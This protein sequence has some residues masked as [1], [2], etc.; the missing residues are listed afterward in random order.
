MNN[1][2]KKYLPYLLPL[3]FLLV[4]A[5]QADIPLA[6]TPTAVWP[7]DSKQVQLTRDIVTIMQEKHFRKQKLDDQFS[8]ALLDNYLAMLDPNHQIFLQSD[9][10]EFAR[11]RNLLD[12]E[13]QIGQLTS[14]RAIYQ[15]FYDRYSSRLAWVATRIDPLLKA[16]E[17]NGDDMIEV[18]RKKSP[19]PADAAAADKL[20]EQYVKNS[21][22]SLQ[23][24]D[25]PTENISA[26]LTRRFHAQLERLQKQTA[27]DNFEIF[28]NAYTEM[29][30]PHT[31]YMSPKSSDNFDISMSLSLEGIGAVLEK[32]DE[33]TKVT[34]LVPAGPAAK[35]GE[36]KP[37]DHIVAIAQGQNGEQWE[38]VIG[39]RLDEVVELI[40][41]KADT[42]VRLQIKRGEDQIKTIAIRREK[43]KLEDQAASKKIIELP[44]DKNGKAYK[45]GVI[46]VPNF[47][48]DF[49]ALRRR[50]PD[51]K[52]TT[53]D[54][55]RILD[56]L[57][58]AK[59]DGV[60]IDL[61]DNG[62][63][64]LLEATQLTNL[65]VDPGPVVQIL[66]ANNEVDRRNRA[67]N[68]AYYK[69][70]LLVLVN[71]LSASASEIFAGA[72]QDYQR[73]LIVGDQTFGK[74]TVQTLISLYQG[75][76]K[77]TE[78]KFYRISGDSTQHRGVVPDISYPA[79]L[80]YDEVGESALEHAL[81]WDQ[82]QPAPHAVYADIHA[83]EPKLE[84]LHEQRM[85]NNPEYNF[86]LE[87]K[88]L[89]GE[90]RKRKE[91]P[92]N[93][94]KREQLKQEEN[95]KILQINNAVRKAEGKPPLKTMTELEE[96]NRKIH[97]EKNPADDF[98]LMES[99]HIL[100]DFISDASTPREVKVANGGNL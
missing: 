71:H 57:Q 17:F 51:T 7:A 6:T 64:S 15:R 67:I 8:S 47:Y 69:G 70:P 77:I 85:V 31:N 11:Y 75:K 43:V 90:Q 66:N 3:L 52:S 54:V 36:I 19:W 96:N 49:E 32:D 61:R 22:L 83:L 87:Q 18:D 44:A 94:A 39:W 56:E 78:A 9:I 92:L 63:G 2:V 20:W 86:L 23:L 100:R 59:V 82:I 30:D 62:G 14:A 12:D 80:P 21:I 34:R 10:E 99:A 25:K 4:P 93:R 41:G 81:P 72:I 24:A 29:Y 35:E 55:R 76:L 74:G 60:M 28:M 1:V 42:W 53:R 88:N 89:L 13:L 5:V 65:F 95:A 98:L 45:I 79:L 46:T 58:A 73:G 38:D 40:R 27:M 37:G 48:L 50:D 91:L 97:D 16:N 68:D 84:K 26:T 33:Y